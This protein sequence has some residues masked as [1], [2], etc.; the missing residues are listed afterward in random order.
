[1]TMPEVTYAP[2]REEI[3]VYFIMDIPELRALAFNKYQRNF[4]ISGHYIFLITCENLFQ[5]H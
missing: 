3:Q 4:G 2:A 1:M 5:L